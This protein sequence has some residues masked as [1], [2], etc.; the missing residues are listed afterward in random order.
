MKVTLEDM[1]WTVETCANGAAAIRKIESKEHYDLLILD[2][3]LGPGVSGLEVARRARQL[4]HRQRTPI[5]MLS[6]SD[7]EPEA[8]R[9]GADAFLM[10]PQDMGNLTAM[11]TRL[12]SKK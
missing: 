12:L 4:R 5:I 6:G 11:V 3:D 9:A 7:I 2:N 8:W 1:A 10:K